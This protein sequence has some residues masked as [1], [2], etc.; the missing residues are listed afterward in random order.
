MYNFS[1]MLNSNKRLRQLYLLYTFRMAREF[2]AQNQVQQQYRDVIIMAGN[3]ETDYGDDGDGDGD[4]THYATQ[5]L[6]TITK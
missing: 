2:L 5:Y 4:D 3:Q 1:I 6:H